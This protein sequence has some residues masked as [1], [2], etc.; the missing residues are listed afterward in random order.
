MQGVVNRPENPMKFIFIPPAEIL[1]RAQINSAWDMKFSPLSARVP[2][3][4]A[5][6]V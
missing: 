2:R 4:H 1:S 5:V 3:H 6:T